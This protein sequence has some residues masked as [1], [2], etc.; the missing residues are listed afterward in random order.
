MTARPA[1]NRG[2]VTGKDNA[3][4][5]VTGAECNDLAGALP[6]RQRR[7]RHTRNAILAAVKSALRDGSLQNATVHDLAGTAG[8]SIGAFYGRFES[9]DAA[10]AAL[11][12]E[13]RQLFVEKLRALNAQAQTLSVW[14]DAAVALALEHA[15]SNRDLMAWAARGDAFFS[16]IANAARTDSIALAEDLGC[17][18]K[19]M[20]PSLQENDANSV[21]AFAIAMLGGMTRDAAVFSSSLLGEGAT[22]SW[23]AGNL[24]NAIECFVT[25]H[26]A[27]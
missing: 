3:P 2:H 6:V 4:G 23:F 20:V 16:V 10:I 1:M 25:S 19:R 8:V 9:K 26:K 12:N 11:F 13:R 14:T 18:F 24:A 21:A 17:H 27:G 15:F 5:E 22:R 7:S